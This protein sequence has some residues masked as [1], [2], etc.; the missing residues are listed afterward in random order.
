[1]KLRPHHLLCIQKFTGHGYDENFTKHMTE[2]VKVLNSG[3]EITLHEGCDDV[4]L[5]CPNNYFGKCKSYHK[6]KE[7]DE[8][9][10]YSCNLSY[11]K[12]IEWNSVSSIAKE[13][14]LDSNMFDSICGKC[15]W[16]KLCKNTK[17]TSWITH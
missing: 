1:M 4:C 17:E 10:L 12:A 8:N 3:C 13:I 7:L 11:G 5:Q 16:Y 6:V 15:E 9:V 2:I 14:I